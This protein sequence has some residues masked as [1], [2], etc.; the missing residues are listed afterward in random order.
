VRCWL[1]GFNAILWAINTIPTPEPLFLPHPT[2]FGF[3]VSD[4]HKAAL[5][6]P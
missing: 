2:I 6:K 4:C 1:F 3:C 5:K